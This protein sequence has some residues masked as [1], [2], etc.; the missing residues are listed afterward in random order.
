MP[1]HSPPFLACTDAGSGWAPLWSAPGAGVEAISPGCCPRVWARPKEMDIKRVMAVSALA[2]TTAGLASAAYQAAGEATDRRRQRPP[3]RL[4]EAGGH[5]LRIVCAG[6]GSPAVVIIS[7][8]GGSCSGWLGLQQ[9]LAQKTA[10]CVYDRSGIG[11]SDPPPTRRTGAHMA[12][13]LHALL[14][15]AGV[16]PPY[17]LVGHSLGGL[18]A[19]IFAH[20]YPAEIAG[21]ALIDSSH[22]EQS[23][24]LPKTELQELPRGHAPPGSAMAGETTRVASHG[25]GSWPQRD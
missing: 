6:E 17:A 16:A 7:A 9:R 11:W 4:V 18:V 3:G 25:P 14:H 24:R 13:E 23:W 22:P 5:R 20:L 1:H 15:N 10:V 12:R 21:I 2:A 19:R 8:L